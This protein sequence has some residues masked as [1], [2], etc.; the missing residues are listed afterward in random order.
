MNN[1]EK[2]LALLEQVVTDVADLKTDVAD[3]KTDVSSLKTTVASLEVRVDETAALAQKTAVLLE[4]DVA[5]KI[6]LLYE[7]H[8]TI[9]D[10]LNDLT[11]T[12]SR[13]EVLEADMAIMK[14]AYKLL[15]Q[16]VNELKKA[17]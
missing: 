15:R 10:K 12:K 2:I 17:Q 6:N 3:L 1:E 7:G 16:E 9:M 4:N 14:D 11:S 8:E 5:H 13:V